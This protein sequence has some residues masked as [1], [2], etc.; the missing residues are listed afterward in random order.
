MSL[1]NPGN[2][3]SQ[4]TELCFQPLGSWDRISLEFQLFS[5]T[6]LPNFLTIPP[7]PA[8]SN[9]NGVQEKKDKK[10]NKNKIKNVTH[11]PINFHFF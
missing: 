5:W 4:E 6:N 9:K 3:E 7:L 10:E 8:P 2:A 11:F 1:L